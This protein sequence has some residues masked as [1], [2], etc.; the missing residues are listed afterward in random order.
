MNI[1]N[2]KNI[3]KLNLEEFEII[4]CILDFKKEKN[5]DIKSLYFLYFIKSIE[6]NILE[7]NTLLSIVLNKLDNN[8]N[9]YYYNLIILCLR[10]GANS[11]LYL[12]SK[13]GDIHIILYIVLSMRESNINL[14][15][16][17]FLIYCFMIMGS[18]L[19][20]NSFIQENI[21]EEI[22]TN[23]NID[24]S[25]ISTILG[26]PKINEKPIQNNISIVDWLYNNGIGQF[27]KIVSG[28]QINILNLNE[29]IFENKT[30]KPNYKK[31]LA[32][33]CDNAEY[34]LNIIDSEFLNIELI[35]KFRSFNIL[36][37]LPNNDYY[38]CIK[39][40]KGGH[41]FGL[42]ISIDICS[43]ESFK[44]FFDKGLILNYFTLNILLLKIKHSYDINGKII[45]DEL[46]NILKYSIE[47]GTHLD[48]EQL[49]LIT[50]SS[51]QLEDDIK[52]IYGKPMWKKVCENTSSNYI[53]ENLKKI[54]F[55]LNLDFSDTK[56]NICE[57][58]NK[59][60]SIPNKETLKQS[61]QNRQ[62]KKM[63]NELSLI[64]DYINNEPPLIV[65]ENLNDGFDYTDYSISY[66]KDSNQKT[67]CFLS[68]MYE[69]LLKNKINPNTNE[70]L[71]ELFNEQ[72]EYKFNILNKLNIKYSTPKT[73]LESIDEL[74]IND[75]INNEE[76]DFIV[77]TIYSLAFMYKIVKKDFIDLTNEKMNL[78]LSFLNME[79]DYFLYKI[80]INTPTQVPTQVS[81][82]TFNHS[83]IT[84][85]RA[86]YYKTKQNI[87]IIQK[88]F[89]NFKTI[90]KK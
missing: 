12:K 52:L 78:I 83:L 43:F 80:F 39:E 56:S 24:N 16:I 26:K 71:P 76:S 33:I 77:D 50:M 66:Y 9:D 74:E 37:S 34:A 57:N 53:P 6:N 82:I 88:F 29:L 3:S 73:I 60:S 4:D 51:K 42:K 21:S 38:N 89:N 62:Q 90:I 44:H 68:N 31:L 18:N 32:I 14:T 30:I 36:K 15:K 48:L 10:Y 7:S 8:D 70:L 35:I 59:I 22:S 72:I 69:N 13:Y 23:S 2:I 54:A 17:D 84:F 45:I 61:S 40:L 25:F 85:C 46:I 27:K 58:L 64:S 5:E 81:V 11:N 86:I 63:S 49:N 28:H 1:L 79:Q 67:W 41:I 87:D 55:N 65:C 75:K 47:K 19:T 20:Q